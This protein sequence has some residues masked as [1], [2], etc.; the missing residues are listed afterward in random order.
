M[1]DFFAQDGLEQ[2]RANVVAGAPQARDHSGRYIE[3]AC[4]QHHRNHGKAGERVMRGRHGRFPQTVMRGEV[5]ITP[6]ELSQA[7]FQHGE[8]ARFIVSD[9][10]PVIIKFRR[11]ILCSE[12]ADQIPSQID[13]VQFDMRDGVEEG[14]PPAYTAGAAARHQA[15]RQHLRPFGALW[16]VRHNDGRIRRQ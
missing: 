6:T 14:D 12:A 2:S 4:L 10:H 15:G 16:A 1:S 5:A 3:A 7:C 13:G 11:P 8:M 9:A